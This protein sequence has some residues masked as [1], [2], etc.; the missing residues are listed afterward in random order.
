MDDDGAERVR[1]RQI[2]HARDVDEAAD[3]RGVEGLV[4]RADVAAARVEPLEERRRHEGAPERLGEEHGFQQLQVLVVRAAHRHQWPQELLA[5]V[6]AL[7]QSL[8]WRVGTGD[9]GH[10]RRRDDEARSHIDAS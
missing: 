2:R 9:G 6:L 10:E 1:A 7:S 3:G 5:R 8:R 4:E